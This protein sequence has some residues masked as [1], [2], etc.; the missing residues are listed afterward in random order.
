MCLRS[1]HNESNFLAETRFFAGTP[2]IFASFLPKLLRNS[3]KSSIFA[4]N[5]ALRMVAIATKFEPNSMLW[6]YKETTM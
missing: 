2:D 3:E 1:P 6:I 5:F 4:A